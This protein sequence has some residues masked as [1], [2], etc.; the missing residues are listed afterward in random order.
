[1]KN[2]QNIKF[3]GLI[4]LVCIIAVCIGWIEFKENIGNSTIEQFKYYN[5][6]DSIK[7]DNITN[8]TILSNSIID[9]SN[10]EAIRDFSSHIFIATVDSIDGCS[11]IA[12]GQYSPFPTI[13]GKITI[14]KT[15]KGE[16][17]E[18]SISFVRLGGIISLEDLDKNAPT[19]IIENRKKHRI[20]T[21]QENI[22][23]KKTYI[24]Y[25]EK[26]DIELEAGRTYLFFASYIPQSNVYGINGAQYGAREINQKI[27][28]KKVFRSMP[29]ESTLEVK[30]NDTKENESLIELINKYLK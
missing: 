20:E 25:V 23:M 15:Y 4:L 18:K 13:Y 6:T 16:I 12:T 24:K 1:M 8:N 11:T 3:L 19:E 10:F 9:I 2:S 27:T 28:N 14:L 21:G 17:K 29:D 26:N 22:D 30:N 7:S 5:Y